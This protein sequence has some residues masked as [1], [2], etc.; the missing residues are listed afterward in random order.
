MLLKKLIKKSKNKFYRTVSSVY[1]KPLASPTEKEKELIR[2][3][4]TAFSNLPS[5]CM[6]NCSQSEKEWNNNLYRLRELVLNDDP[7][8]FLRWDVILRTMFAAHA[9]YVFPELKYLRTRLDWNS[10][11]SKAI[12]ESRSGHPI[13]HWQYP[14]SSGNLIHHA[15][16][17]AQ[18]EEKTKT[19]VD[20]MNFIIEF[21]GGYG[22]MCRLFYNLG[23]RG[24]YII[25]DLPEFSALQEFFLKSIGIT[26]CSTDSFNNSKEG[27]YCVSDLE[28][29]KAIQSNHE[30]MSN[31]M[32]IATW[33]ISEAPI[34]LRNSILSLISS[35]KA[36][37]IGYQDQFGEVSNI[38]FFKN[39][40]VAHSDI[41]W[42]DW[43]IEHL[44][45]ENRYMMGQK[46]N[47]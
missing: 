22:S 1:D 43:K 26:V 30:E 8:Q 16:H 31:S 15:Y 47:K 13:P 27:A 21:G 42:W 5:L 41:K 7:R 20:G 39:Y 10:R 12:V 36:F 46:K 33:S 4:K 24:K 28:K 44:H 35:F 9:G 37:L 29:L 6:T 3:L 18:F 14:S 23:F 45:S 25:F 11:W 40:A 34:Y 32:F 19:R 38:D 17:V 2:E